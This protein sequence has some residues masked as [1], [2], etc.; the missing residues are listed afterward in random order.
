MWS[1][2]KC[3]CEKRVKSQNVM[4]R[5]SYYYKN[6]RSFQASQV[7]KFATRDGIDVISQSSVY[8][9]GVGRGR[10]PWLMHTK[11]R[12]WCTALIIKKFCNIWCL[13]ALQLS[14]YRQIAVT[15]VYHN[16]KNKLN[17][18]KR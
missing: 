9:F 1:A 14:I 18:L 4:K 7:T 13:L 2:S 8:V 11:L 10:E 12:T 17:R 6:K 15:C 5:W 3:S 16:I